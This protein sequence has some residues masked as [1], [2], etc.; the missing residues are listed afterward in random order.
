MAALNFPSSPVDGQVHTENGRTWHYTAVTNSWSSYNAPTVGMNWR[1]SWDAA[2]S[3]VVDDAVFFNG[4][5]WIT[6]APNSGVNPGTDAAKW[7]MLAARGQDGTNGADGAP[8]APGYSPN[9]LVSG[10]GVAWTGELSFTVSAASYVIGGSLYSSPQTALTLAPAHVTWPR[11]DLI[12]LNIVGAATVLQGIASSTPEIPDVD[13]TTQL[14]L[15]FIYVPATATVP[16]D[17]SA[18]IVYREAAGGEWTAA[19]SASAIVVNSINNP[20]A[21]TKCVEA[22]AVNNQYVQF[23]NA[24]DFDTS[25]R[26][27]L[28][29]NIR[30]KGAWPAARQLSLRWYSGNAGKGSTVSFKD[31][32]FG[33]VSSNNATYQQIIIPLSLFGV[34]GVSVDR[35][36]ITAAGSGATFGFYLDEISL[37]GG[38]NQTSSGS[39]AMTW[40][41]VWNS[42]VAYVKNDVVQYGNATWVALQATTNVLP[43]EGDSWSAVSKYIPLTRSVS[44]AASLMLD[45]GAS[46]FYDVTLTGPLLLTFNNGVDGKVVR[47]RVRQDGVGNRVLTL[48]AG[49]RNGGDLPG[50]L[51][52]TGAN[53]LDYLAF[54]YSLADAKYDLISYNRGF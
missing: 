17:T 33:F 49:I 35:I 31:G 51:L 43:V 38:V 8:G 42:S 28:V 7:D 3:Y 16:V 18:T 27:N 36:R 25:T 52:S 19:A 15:T 45:A 37:Q 20:L 21:G 40:R 41:G 23:T 50:L 12:V 4:S 30:S 53:K 54:Q 39:A 14:Q 6:I 29:L 32:T 34:T 22:T 1:G 24:V 48:G 9:T 13:P 2:A 11:F 44:Y 46:D 47:L 26:N 10:G 5:S